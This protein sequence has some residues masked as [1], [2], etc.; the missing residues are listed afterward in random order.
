MASSSQQY[1]EQYAEYAM[2]QMRLYGIPASITLAQ[3]I[4]ESANGKSRLAQNENNHFG[5]KATK[6]WIN[7]GGRYGLYTDDK[8]N[9]KFC[10]YD[11]V[12]DSY[13]HHSRFLKE[14]S[15][16]AAC[17]T[18]SADDYKG[19]A[20]G[21]D[22]A[23]Y[24]TSGKYAPSLISVIEK[25][26]LSKYDKMVMEEMASKG[27]K[28]GQGVTTGGAVVSSEYSFPL[29]RNEF[30]LVTSTFGLRQ[31]PCNP[32]HE[33][34][35]KGVDLKCNNEALLATEQ[36]GK[37]IAVNENT[38]TPGGKSVTIQYEREDGSK[39]QVYYAHLS[40][41]GV[42]VGDTV[43]AGQQIGVS[44]NTGTRTT[45]PHLH[46]GVK[47]IDADGKARDLDPAIYLAEIA[48][49]GNINIKAM[50]NGTDILEKYK[51]ENP[52]VQDPNR[53]ITNDLDLDLSPEDW[54]KKLLSS[55]DSG[56]GL[57]GMSADPIM[58]MVITMFTSL[59][60]LA[61]TIDNKSEEEKMAIATEAAMNRAIDLSSLVPSMKEC[62]LTINEGSLP[63]LHAND[64]KEKLSIQ[65]N[66]ND[67]NRL[68]LALSDSS[69]DE[70]QKQQRVSSVIGNMIV[71]AKMT[72]SYQ[73]GMSEGQEQNMQLK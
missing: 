15:R 56:I 2:E 17:F 51:A 20:Q 62:Y 70:N 45:G 41:V 24:A 48:S 60:A 55:E 36:N 28:P 18:L 1:V 29:K 61:T 53:E 8:P 52:D 31:D 13:A 49:K 63:V 46:F 43:N 3:G 50:H 54:M 68:N 14:N 7:N 71:N 67:M 73:Q 35:H 33:Q 10:S 21:L 22:K 16:Y 65:M 38:N 12:A 26:D 37:V 34:M 4:L 11:S 58:D 9:E 25:L 57:S 19:W 39:I 27:L 59:M 64:G 23:G 72:Q 30:M 6:A 69:L 5:I 40:S 32:K 47:Q 44:G 66:Q 42:K